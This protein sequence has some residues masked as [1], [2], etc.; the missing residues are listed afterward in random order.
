MFKYLY[1]IFENKITKCKVVS[2]IKSTEFTKICLNDC[3]IEYIKH[4]LLGEI[5]NLYD[6]VVE[7][8]DKNTFTC[9]SI[10][11][12]SIKN[13]KHPYGT[14]EFAGVD[15]NVKLPLN[16]IYNPSWFTTRREAKIGLNKLRGKNKIIDD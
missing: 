4:P 2:I 9:V 3:C 15:L 13:Q 1:C 11:E 5:I 6:A 14:T 10:Y 7:Y 8:P 16:S 12:R